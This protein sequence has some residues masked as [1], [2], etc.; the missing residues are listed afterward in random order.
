MADPEILGYLNEENLYFEEIMAPHKSL[1]DA[2]FHEI[3]DRQPTEESSVPFEENGF[4][5]Q[6]R[7][8]EGEEYRTWYRAPSSR[9]EDWSVLLDERELA[10]S[11]DYFN[12]GGISVSDDGN[13]ITYSIDRDGSE[14][15]H[16]TGP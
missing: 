6:W 2:L 9:P 5:Y 10:A 13:R 4:F 8:H 7:F 11:S 15:A 1:I 3:K 16:S 12:L 14:R